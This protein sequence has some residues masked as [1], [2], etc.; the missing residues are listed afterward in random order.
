[1]DEDLDFVAN[2]A[3]ELAVVDDLQVAA[4]AAA[5]AEDSSSSSSEQ[6]TSSSSTD[7]SDNDEETSSNATS[8]DDEDMYNSSDSE[9]EEEQTHT[10]HD[11]PVAN[12]PPPPPLSSS[13]IALSFSE[14]TDAGVKIA[15]HLSNPSQFQVRDL[16]ADMAST[17]SDDDSGDEDIAE[18]HSYEDLRQVVD[19]MDDPE[20]TNTTNPA[21][22]SA[23]E[24]LFGTAPPPFGTALNTIVIAP[25]DPM[26]FAGRIMSVIEGTVVVK[27]AE[28]SRALNEGALLVLE[29]RSPLGWVEDIF[30]PVQSPLYA[31]RYTSNSSN[32]ALPSQSV[33]LKET[34]V[35]SVDKYAQYLA[36]DELRVKGYDDVV[37][38]EER[39]GEEKD[40]ELQFSDDEAEAQFKRKLKSKRKQAQVHQ[41]EDGGGGGGQ[42]QRGGGRGGRH[43]KQHASLYARG[44]G[45]RG[46]GTSFGAGP[47]PPPHHQQT[48]Q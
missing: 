27:A 20:D 13:K 19:A 26:T 7:D 40:V 12:R 48:Q 25:T 33:L 31:L 38:A 22:L 41:G 9:E 8:S 18:I 46:R 23:A 3:G 47:P 39:E 4:A 44:G 5:A 36:P 29:D 1:M 32:D 35:Y 42:Q 14:I 6:D 21:A 30:G 17:E 28:G 34:K 45:G 24:A 10:A 37:E 2:Q 16:E 43:R 15:F 11:R